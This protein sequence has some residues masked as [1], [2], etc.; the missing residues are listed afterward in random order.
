MKEIYI[1]LN[2]WGIE[3]DK[4]IILFRLLLNW[5]IIYYV[6]NLMIDFELKYLNLILIF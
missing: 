6:F 1:L 2:S 5:I 3:Y 4:K